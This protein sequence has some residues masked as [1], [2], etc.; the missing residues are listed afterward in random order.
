[1]VWL[2]DLRPEILLA[3]SVAKSTNSAL[4][5]LCLKGRS[6]EKG[7]TRYV[8]GADPTNAISAFQ[9]RAHPFGQP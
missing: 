8:P 2:I 9:G 3:S 7:L 5:S 6:L 1:M 4:P